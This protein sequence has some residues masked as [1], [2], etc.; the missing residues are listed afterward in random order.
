MLEFVRG[1]LAGALWVALC[2]GLLFHWQRYAL[3]PVDLLPSNFMVLWGA[4]VLLAGAVALSVPSLW[5][6]SALWLAT[7]ALLPFDLWP[8][9]LLLFGGVPLLVRSHRKWCWCAA[10]VLAIPALLY[11]S[12]ERIYG[13]LNEDA[14]AA[15]MQTRPHEAFDYARQLLT[16]GMLAAWLAYAVALGLVLRRMG[17]RTAPKRSPAGLL[18]A[19]LCVLLVLPGALTRA[20]VVKIALRSDP[21]RMSFGSPPDGPHVDAA[22]ADLDVVLLVGEATARGF[23]SLYGFPVQTTP[24]LDARRDEL[25]IF[26]DAVSSHSHTVPSLRNLFYR[27]TP[28]VSPSQESRQVSLVDLLRRAGVR[29]LWYSAQEAMGPWAAP[30]TRLG[31]AA[32]THQYLNK[33]SGFGFLGEAP[34]AHPDR[35]AH[36]AVLRSLAVP[37][38]GPRL[39]V[40]H[41]YAAHS[42]YCAH[43]P[44]ES[45]PVPLRDGEAFFGEGPD[46]SANLRCYADAMRMVDELVSSTMDA[47]ARSKRPTIVLFSPDHGEAPELGTGHNSQRHSAHHVEIPMVVYFNAAAQRAQQPLYEV[48]QRRR[49]LPFMNEWLFELL[50]DFYGL[51]GDGLLLRTR[52]PASPDYHPPARILFADTRRWNYDQREPSRPMDVLSDTRLSLRLLHE[53]GNVGPTIFAHR[54]DT[55][56][57]ALAARDL[58]D[59]VEMDIVFDPAL[60]TL[61]V[62]HPPKRPTGLLL[63]DQ[64]AALGAQPRLRVWLDMK[65]PTAEN[66]PQILQQ[67]DA[68]DRQWRIRDRAIVE[69]PSSLDAT[70]LD[71]YARAQWRV[72][73]YL[74]DDLVGCNV[75]PPGDASCTKRVSDWMARAVT[76]KATYF[77][78]DR[79]SW[80]AV[81]SFV[82]PH[83]PAGMRLLSWDLSLR[84]DRPDLVEQLQR[85]PPLDGFIVPF[86]TA[87]DR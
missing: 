33:Q 52:S 78:F 5:Q 42:P 85:L 49:G 8:L 77:S 11:V 50:L 74:P 25:V 80:P 60:Q 47:A 32:D 15:I 3:L 35:L 67:L 79:A 43:V 66:A 9:A 31:E 63:A 75:A 73:L 81:K 13:P 55:Q 27:D 57:K 2:A 29:V 18:A 28:S 51:P 1:R 38:T 53:Q 76:A 20:Q 64:L 59:G 10:V 14:V 65:N 19:V 39:L 26:T 34:S 16:P 41:F 46:F 40:H 82:V 87:F 36:A 44:D 68:L 48:L 58:F 23:W 37:A 54:V 30:I 61:L 21:T 56:G 84:S 24:H 22:H 69:L 70:T 12:N 71:S 17:S 7:M 62:N 86:R 6:V 4:W 83:M 45:L 72:S